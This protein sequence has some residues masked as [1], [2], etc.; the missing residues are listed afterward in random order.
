MSRSTLLPIALLVLLQGVV[1]TQSSVSKRSPMI[2]FGG[3]PAILRLRGGTGSRAIPKSV[4]NIFKADDAAKLE[5]VLAKETVTLEMLSK[6]KDTLVHL[7]TRA[8][9]KECLAALLASGIDANVRRADNGATALMLAAQNGHP[10]CMEILLANGAVAN[11]VQ[12]EGTAALHYACR[13]G[14]VECIRLLLATPKID[15]NVARVDGITPLMVAAFNGRDD[16]VAMLLGSKAKADVSLRS[17]EHLS[18]IDYACREG[19]AAVTQQLLDAKAPM[20]QGI[21]QLGNTAPVHWA[22]AGGHAKVLK[23]LLRAGASADALRADGSN[24]LH[25]AALRGHTDCVELLLGAGLDANARRG[26]DGVPPLHL[27]AQ[28]GNVECV[29]ALLGRGAN[30]N[31]CVRN[32]VKS[33]DG[34]GLVEKS[35]ALDLA[36]QARQK[37][38][39]KI[40]ELAGGKSGVLL[41]DSTLGSESALAAAAA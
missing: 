3:N 26:A 2:G 1:V 12:A 23:I 31:A 32:A 20:D 25:Y 28:Q 6:D 15:V 40:L 13:W 8:D 14:H 10:E 18:A 29:R 37:G 41:P 35:S 21:P 22:S 7:A 39:I 27:A 34:K 5:E 17:A 11:E 16:C 19:Y 30:V 38:C 4:L 24:S 9:A 36:M 33:G